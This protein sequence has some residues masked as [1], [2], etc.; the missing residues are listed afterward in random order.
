MS[1]DSWVSPQRAKTARICSSDWT[2]HGSTKVEPIDSAS[3][4]TRRSIRLSTDEKPTS[5]PSSW[6]A[7]AIPQ[8]IE[9][10]LATPKISAFLP[11]SSPID[12]L[13]RSVPAA[14][15]RDP[16]TLRAMR[17]TD[18]PPSATRSAASGRCCSIS[19]A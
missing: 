4:R 9:W 18:P 2:S 8:A 1:S 16:S 5:A 10:S 13:L 11:S 12:L 15:P 17:T 19:M 6:S 3:G 7:R 14:Y